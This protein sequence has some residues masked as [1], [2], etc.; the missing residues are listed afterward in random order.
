[1]G[2]TNGSKSNNATLVSIRESNSIF[3]VVVVVE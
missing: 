3:V 1:M 2:N